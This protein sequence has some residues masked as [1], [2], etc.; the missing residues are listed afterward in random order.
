MKRKSDKAALD[1]LSDSV[2]FRL[3]RELMKPLGYHWYEDK[4]KRA[5]GYFEVDMPGTGIKWR[6]FVDR[7]YMF[8]VPMENPPKV[9]DIHYSFP[10]PFG[11]WFHRTIVWEDGK[12]THKQ[13]RTTKTFLLRKYDII[14][15]YLALKEKMKF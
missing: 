11:I 8:Y 14:T 3:M 12:K 1:M 4:R 2:L 7:N 13:F 10:F 15:D 6:S 9:K 5:G